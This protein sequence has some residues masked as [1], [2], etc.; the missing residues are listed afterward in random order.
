[1]AN[2]IVFNQ[3]E[4]WVGGRES[5]ELYATTDN[6]KFKC[7]ISREAI[8]DKYGL[9]GSKSMTIKAFKENRDYFENVAKKLI[10]SGRFDRNNEVVIRYSDC[11]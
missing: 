10:Q 2:D 1:M 9:T 3:K 6:Q 8:D 7:L 5:I 4:L 11:A